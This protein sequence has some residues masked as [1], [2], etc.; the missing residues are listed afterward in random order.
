MKT[1]Q[2]VVLAS[3]LLATLGTLTV[4]FFAM[5]TTSQ[6]SFESARAQENYL[7]YSSQLADLEA[8]QQR[9]E[10]RMGEIPAE[11]TKAWRL[12]GQGIVNNAFNNTKTA[13]EEI[14]CEQYVEL[15]GELGRLVVREARLPTEIQSA[16]NQKNDWQVQALAA[17]HNF[18]ATMTFWVV[19]TALMAI[20]AMVFWILFF[21]SKESR[22]VKALET[23]F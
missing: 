6:A 19:G 15:E 13:A 22:N 9:T 16:R 14:A 3:A 11:S 12:C 18:T 2:A 23:N 10:K 21:R 17:E 7:D 5:E 4:G 20:T 8:E 1:S